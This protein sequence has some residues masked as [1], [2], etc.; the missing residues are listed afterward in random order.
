[1]IFLKVIPRRTNLIL[2]KGK[3]LSPRFTVSFQVLKKVGSLVYKLELPAHVKVHLVFHVSFVEKVYA[4]PH[5]VLQ[6]NYNL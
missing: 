4:N 2:G 1:M 6:E 3:H 5:H